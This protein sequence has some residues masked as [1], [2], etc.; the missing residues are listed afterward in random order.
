MSTSSTAISVLGAAALTGTW[1]IRGPKNC[2]E[3]LPLS[4]ELASVL[5]D[6][7]GYDAKWDRGEWLFPSVRKTAS[8]QDLSLI[9][10]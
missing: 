10:I 4:R 7:I 9:H 5:P 6:Q 8:V 2:G 1:T 3:P